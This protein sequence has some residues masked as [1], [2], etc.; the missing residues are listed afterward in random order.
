[1][2][3]AVQQNQNVLYYLSTAKP[4][5]IKAI[6]KASDKTLLKAIQEL[7]KNG[8]YTDLG[9]EPETVKRLKVHKRIL[10]RL[11]DTKIGY[12]TLRRHL[13][14]TGWKILPILIPPLLKVLH[15]LITT[16]NNG[17]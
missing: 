8:L 3:K 4:K 13:L 10:K 9:L 6:L 7:A 17:D 2:S 15:S 11:A 5:Y 16:D 14:R 1:M 12:A